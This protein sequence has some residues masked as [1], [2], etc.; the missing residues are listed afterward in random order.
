[1]RSPG[2]DGLASS[3]HKM[4][5]ELKRMFIPRG[6]PIQPDAR[7]EDPVLEPSFHSTT[8][9]SFDPP[10]ICRAVGAVRVGKLVPPTP[11]T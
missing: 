7:D 3:R 1:M 2:S 5:S 9:F 8:R 6:V 11:I 10:V 4:K